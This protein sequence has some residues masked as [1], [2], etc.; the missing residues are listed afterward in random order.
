MAVK[1]VKAPQTK[2]VINLIVWDTENYPVNGIRELKFFANPKTNR[3]LSNL[4]QGG[5]L[6]KGYV[7]FTKKIG[8]K[9]IPKFVNSYEPMD[10]KII[11]KLN[12]PVFSLY[13]QDKKKFEIPMD[14]VP[15]GI[16]IYS[17]I[18]VPPNSLGEMTGF[19]TNGIPIST[20]FFELNPKIKIEGETNFNALIEFKAIDLIP[21]ANE[22]YIRTMLIGYA[23]RPAR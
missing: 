20:N 11:F 17:T 2:E 5:Q 15:S 4:E 18:N 8:I 22:Y 13:V 9:V 6:P 12:Q 10:L 16:D 1:E 3:Y 21:T 7:F 14:L 23:S 19:A